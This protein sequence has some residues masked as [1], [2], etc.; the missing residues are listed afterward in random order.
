MDEQQVVFSGTRI[1]VSTSV[2]GVHQFSAT[3]RTRE[4]ETD[5]ELL[6]RLRA[7]TDKLDELYPGGVEA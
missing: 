6:V 2:K 5:D 4:D 3:V 1:E 7:L